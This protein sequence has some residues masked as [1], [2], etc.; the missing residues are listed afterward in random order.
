MP[1]IRTISDLFIFKRQLKSHPLSAE[2]V[3]CSIILP[4]SYI[5][6]LQVWYTAELITMIIIEG[7]TAR[8]SQSCRSIL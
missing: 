6:R 1:N 7:A 5:F 2:L 3:F 8:G 4:V